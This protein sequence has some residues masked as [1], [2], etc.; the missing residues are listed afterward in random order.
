MFHRLGG[1]MESEI[2]R[3]ASEAFGA[4]VT[5]DDV[6]LDLI[7]GVVRIK[8]LTIG[9]PPGV[10]GENALV[11]GSIEAAFD[12]ESK[13]VSR[14]VFDRARIHIEEIDG[15]TN[16]QRLK[17]SLESNISRET[18]APS[19]SGEELVIRRFLMKSTTAV[20]ESATLERISEVEIDEIE[21]HDLR[22]TPEQ[23]AEVIAIR[24]LD[25][26]TQ[27]AGQAMLRGQAR[28]QL[29]DVEGKVG[30]KLRELLGGDSDGEGG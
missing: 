1:M 16:V 12:F 20:L 5:V 8:G 14:V 2:Q 13:E 3:A 18:G 21:M 6:Q 9:N 26:I 29:E 15:E 7:N 19:G 4:P 10:S 24:L 17:Q 25:E 28:Q 11:F 30:E 23:L 22:G 27:E